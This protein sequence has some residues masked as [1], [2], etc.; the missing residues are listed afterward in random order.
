MVSTSEKI[1]QRLASQVADELG[2]E[3]VEVSLLG[4][5]KRSLLRVIIDRE[6]G[7]TLDDCATFS[8]RFESSMDVENVIAQS[9]TLEV[10][11][12]GLDRP[13]KTLN[14]FKKNIGKLVRITTKE[15][16][17]NQSFF[18]GRLLDIRD[19]ILKISLCEKR[20]TPEEIDIPCDKIA[21][22]QLEI[23]VH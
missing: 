15:M 22:A 5:G 12:P 3:L 23:E 6:G 13:L 2:F 20:G 1:I 16:I 18:Q 8:R 19:T 9:Y 11:S 4:R 17:H 10:S 21:K 14:D 7:I